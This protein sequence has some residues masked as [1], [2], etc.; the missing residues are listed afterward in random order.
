MRTG[1]DATAGDP[2]RPERVAAQ[3]PLGRAGE[4]DEIAAAI[5]WLLS[6]ACPYA[7]GATLRVAGGR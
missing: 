3:V 5:V 6:D 7:T 2:D 4:A 1:I